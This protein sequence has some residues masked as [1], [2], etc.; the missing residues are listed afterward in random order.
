MWFK[1]LF[2]LICLMYKQCFLL[3][4]INSSQA[5]RPTNISS[6]TMKV[7]QRGLLTQRSHSLTIFCYLI[8]A[9]PI[10]YAY[11]YCFWGISSLNC[12]Y[13]TLAYIQGQGS[14]TIVR[15]WFPVFG[16]NINVL[17]SFQHMISRIRYHSWYMEIT[18]DGYECT[19]LVHHQ[20][21]YLQLRGMKSRE[22]ISVLHSFNNLIQFSVCVI[23]VSHYIVAHF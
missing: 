22:R 1:F 7:F 16:M 11:V 18:A 10:Y 8:V 5:D 3:Q 19:T 15:K 14:S 23:N 13:F 4:L 6:S 17:L 21:I 20:R 9:E 12:V 2:L